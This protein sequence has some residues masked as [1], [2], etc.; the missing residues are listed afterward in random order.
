[1]EK[2]D[3]KVKQTEE[4]TYTDADVAQEV[5]DSIDTPQAIIID[6]VQNAAPKQVNFKTLTREEINQLSVKGIEKLLDNGGLSINTVNALEAKLTRLHITKSTRPH[7]STF[8]AAIAAV[9]AAL[10]I[11]KP[12]ITD[13]LERFQQSQPAQSIQL[14]TSTQD[15]SDVKQI[16]QQKE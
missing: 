9:I 12:W 10:P 13:L 2:L 11:V 4:T 5:L 3:I 1:M 6:S 7:W 14:E 16:S 15:N 8:V